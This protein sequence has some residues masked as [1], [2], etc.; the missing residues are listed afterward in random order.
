MTMQHVLSRLV[1][2]VVLIAP[3]AAALG[4][5][6]RAT[7]PAP[8]AATTQPAATT[9]PTAGGLNPS[10]EGFD[11]IGSDAKAIETAD[12]VMAHLGGRGAWDETR[13]L[14][15]S[16]FGR[17]FHLWDKQTGTIRVE[18][19]RGPMGRFVVVMNLKTRRGKVWKDGE[20]LTEPYPIS[21]M[22]RAGREAWINDAYWMFM[23]YK[24]KDSGVTLR[25]LGV[26]PMANDQPAEVLE[27]TFSDVGV[28]PG[29]MYHVYVG[30]ES[31]LVEQWD[32]FKTR[33]QE[34]PSFTTPWENWKRYGRIMLSDSRGEKRT[35]APVG[36]WD[37]MPEAA[38]TSPDPVD[39]KQAKAAK[40]S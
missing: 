10:A 14:T 27:L 37:E 6:A 4:P 13:Y 24:L 3:V 39:L 28:T 32:F 17:R 38:F 25:Y 31:G 18:L 33:D 5:L 35:L 7:P 9:R 30:L 26:K 19:D 15:W 36:V 2:G 12:R 1:V 20:L 40:G 23:P 16:F 29:N 34:E 8:P 11:E 21:Q 22:L